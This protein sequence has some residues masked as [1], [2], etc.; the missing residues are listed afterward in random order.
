[1][2]MGDRDGEQA[3]M[4]YLG[5]GLNTPALLRVVMGCGGGA[6]GR[7]AV[8]GSG[9]V[10]S[11]DDEGAGADGG[12]LVATSMAGVLAGWAAGGEGVSDTG[13]IDG[14]VAEGG[15]G[16]C[17]SRIVGAE[18]PSDVGVWAACGG[19]ELGVAVED[20]V[21]GGVCGGEDNRHGT[22]GDL[23]AG[24]WR[25]GGVGAGAASS[26][27]SPGG[28]MQLGGGGVSRSLKGKH[29]SLKM[30]CRDVMTRRVWMSR[31]RYPR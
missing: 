22:S 4:A 11:L 17:A 25:R 9:R 12:E 20:A 24:T 16:A 26:S 14:D 5:L 21:W 7:D 19:S 18:G 15:V 27:P 31:Q 1:L 13:D 30:T 28:C 8:S 29:R 6:I 10:G 3:V 2:G 23:G